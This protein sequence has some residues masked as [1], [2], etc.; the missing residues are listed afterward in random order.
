MRT[1]AEQD[2]E[3]AFKN[4]KSLWKFIGILAI[5]QLAIIPVTMIFGIIAAI[6]GTLSQL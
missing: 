5:I 6:V 2:L 4:N 3:L 1:G